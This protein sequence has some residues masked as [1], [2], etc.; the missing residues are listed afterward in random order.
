ML[1]IY[2]RHRSDCKHRLEG[3]KY[4]RCHCPIWV[5]GILSNHEIRKSTGLRDWAKAQ[6]LV[7]DWEAEGQLTPEPKVEPITIKK[8]CEEFLQDAVARN[9]RE[10]TVYKYSLLF[11][12]LQNFAQTCGFKFV[13]ELDPAALRRFRAMWADGNLAALKKLE[14]LKSFFRLAQSS[15][16]I[17][18]NAAAELKSPKVTARP[19]LPFT[20]H[21]MIRILQGCDKYPGDG[22]KASPLEVY[23]LRALVLFLRYSGM[24]I[25]DAVSCAVDRVNGDKLLL[26][27]QKTSV[28]VYCPLPNF[29]VKALEAVPHVS[30][31]YFFWTGDSKLPTA[32]G[33]W[34]AKLKKVF[35]LGE[36]QDGHAHRFRDTFAVELLLAGVPLERVSVMLGHSSIKVTERHYAPWVL[37]RQEQAEADVRRAWS[38][39]P[40][41]LLE[42]KGTLEVHEKPGVVN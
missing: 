8:A 41:A 22:H 1:N 5:D 40:V 20:H 4:R 11:R 19:T 25:G 2:R 26:Y 6:A 35:E 3:R 39:D 29:V 36:V 21:E 30:N 16:W 17:E 23:R 42:T 15:K 27:T 34:Q 13:K 10:K 14:R 37:A 12:Q 33:H 18:V 38:Q 31:R 28:P 7:R 9:L 32:T 24:R